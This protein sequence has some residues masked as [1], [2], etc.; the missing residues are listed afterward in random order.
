MGAIDRNRVKLSFGRQAHDYDKHA[1]IQKNVI[2]RFPEILLGGVACPDRILDMGTGTGMLLER[3]SGIF[4][5]ARLYGIDL[6]LDMTRVARRNVPD[7]RMA[8][9]LAAD[10]ELLP[11]AD[12]A[13]GLVVSTSTFQ[14]MDMLGPAFEEA[15]RVLEDGGT[16]CFA[17]FGES[18]LHE[19][20]SSYR[21]ALASFGRPGEDRTHTFH[22][23]RQVGESLARAGFVDCSATSEKYLEHHDNVPA[24]LRSIKNIG[25]GSAARVP[26][27]GLAGRRV[28]QGMIDSYVSLYRSEGKI[29]ATYEVIYARGVKR[30]C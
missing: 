25:A 19:L 12:G 27:P 18:T 17:L 5:D 30:S 22:T 23:V 20:K 26:L 15:F 29:P 7:G 13:F 10:A 28:L 16:F 1:E 9:F 6:A 24:L 4:P 11:F 21:R 2:G 3:I 14:W 8:D